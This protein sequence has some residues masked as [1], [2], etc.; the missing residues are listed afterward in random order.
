MDE[1]NRVIDAWNSWMDSNGRNDYTAI[2]LTPHFTAASFPCEVGWLGVW[3]DG[4]ALAG[5]QEWLTEGASINEDFQ[6]AY[7]S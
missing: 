4:G 3:K 5:L 1:L 6:T 2:V 7:P